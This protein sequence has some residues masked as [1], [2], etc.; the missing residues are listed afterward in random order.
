MY[1]RDRFV[2]SSNLQ[3]LTCSEEHPLTLRRESYLLPEHYSTPSK[4]ELGRVAYARRRTMLSDNGN[5][6]RAGE[7]AKKIGLDLNETREHIDTGKVSAQRVFSEALAKVVQAH[8][9]FMR[10]IDGDALIAEQLKLRPHMIIGEEDLVLPSLMRV[11]LLDPPT[12]GFDP[13][14]QNTHN[15]AKSFLIIDR[16]HWRSW[17][18]NKLRFLEL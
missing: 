2:F 16:T 11:G 3:D 5:W 13:V 8:D 9:E 15:V 14:M 1:K 12:V 18:R 7:L 4:L 17:W 6:S 10:G